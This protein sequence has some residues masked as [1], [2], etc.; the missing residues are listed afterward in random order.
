MVNNLMASVRVY[1]GEELCEQVSASDSAITCK[2]PSS[3]PKG[4]D[5]NGKAAVGV[6]QR[7]T[8]NSWG[9][10]KVNSQQLG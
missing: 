6:S 2:P 3:V 8:L 10:S 1:V 9:K 5:T 7:S 4:T